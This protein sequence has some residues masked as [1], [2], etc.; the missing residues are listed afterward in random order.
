M[1]EAKKKPTHAVHVHPS[2]GIHIQGHG[3]HKKGRHELA[4][5]D[6]DL[7][8]LPK[9]EGITIKSLLEEKAAKPEGKPGDTE[10]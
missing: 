1:A 6:E 3:H 8:I 5:T 4:L 9:A 2:N 10:K 7:E